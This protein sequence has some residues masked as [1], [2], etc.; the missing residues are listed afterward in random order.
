VGV[1]KT[2]NLQQYLPRLVRYWD[3]DAPGRLHRS[4]EGSMVFVDISGFTKMSERLARHGNVGA[5]EVTEVIDNTFG[6]LLPEAYAFG[7]NLLK[8][9]GDALL[10]LFT[11]EGHQQRAVAGAHAMRIKLREVGTF[12]TT[13]GKVS[14]RMSVGVHS[15]DFDFFLVGD[16]HREFIV[17][18]PAASRTVEMEGAA[19]ANQILISP[20][21]ASHLEPSL[22][23]KPAGPGILLRG[24]P[25]VD[26][27]EF[28]SAT[29]P[30]T[31]LGQFIPTALREV[32]GE[33]RV[34]PEHRATTVAFLHY[35]GFD[36]LLANE[37]GETAGEILQRLIA[38]VQHAADERDVT[39]LATDV[40]PDGGKVILTAGVP[41][42]RGNDEERMLLTLR[43]IAT[44]T[45][46]ELPL[47]IGV[48]RGPVFSGVVGP[49][50]RRTYTV[51]GDVVNLA[52]RLM[53][54]APEGE[55]YSTEEVV[56]AS[57]TIF[58][59]TK[60][61]P[62]FVK[63]KSAAIQAY[64]VAD[65]SGS[66]AAA[67]GHDA[68]LIGRESE[69]KTLLDA[70]G[71]ARE[72][73]GQVVEIAAEVGMGKSRLLQEFFSQA[74]ADRVIT[75]ECRL[76]QA[77]TPYFP[78][79]AM[80]RDVW[81]LNDR[82]EEVNRKRLGELVDAHAPHLRPWMSLLA[83]PLDL[84][85][86]R[87]PEVAQLEDQFRPARTLATV[88]GL[89]ESTVEDPTVFVI[90]DNH[91][92]DDSSGELLEGLIQQAEHD[93][94][95]FVLTRRPGV[96]GFVAAELPGVKRLDLGPL[97]FDDARRFI[98]D[99]TRDAPLL[100]RH[101]DLLAERA[102][103]RP[104]FLLE[105]IEEVRSGGD[106]ETL[107]SSVEGLIGSRIDRLAPPDRNLLRRLAVLGTG[108]RL[109]YTGAVLREGEVETRKQYLKRLG[110]FLV[111]DASGWIQF[112]NALIRDVAYEGLPFKTR[113]ELHARVGDSILRA[114]GDDPESEAALLSI[115][116]FHARHWDDAWHFS[117][118]AG[119]DAKAV[120]ANQTAATFFQRALTA[121]R[122]LDVTVEERAE[123]AEALGDVL[124]QAGRAEE[125]LAVYGRALKIIGDDP[126]RRADILLKRAQV[127]MRT[128]DFAIALRD[129]AVGIAAA[130]PRRQPRR[131]ASNSEVDGAAFDRA[132]GPGTGPRGTEDRP[133]YGGRSTFRGREHR[134]GARPRH[135]G[136]GQLRNG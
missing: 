23:G 57:R 81:G 128:G 71:L 15:G 3:E 97:S 21:T 14:L 125:A 38:N 12:Q 52:A 74:R 120:Y 131:K 82:D 124:E 80:L 53:A 132:D 100:P 43:S 122:Y 104:L 13:A 54:K 102:E 55:I 134:P 19:S 116:Y 31:N 46:E 5:E 22:L 87:S 11:N 85:L 68:P 28:R 75:T 107:P 40:A 136:L 9:G 114:A 25:E 79:R 7:A 133:G 95:M 110:E 90:E 29:S 49:W 67:T 99:A 103:G 16:S 73:E 1:N 24:A 89:L 33:E 92:M 18:G 65:P 101:I 129:S 34:E 115:H 86:E 88:S 70:W 98:I 123:V 50:Y 56:N 4:I 119:N 69:L 63:G 111:M 32:L 84:D 41:H 64:S 60:P 51:M 94:W 83:A 42:T 93:P 37:G 66:R 135:H 130:G 2:P 109:E 76:Y 106:I 20:E 112:R 61:E 127:R 108:F 91:W 44:S 17:A 30:P 121:A 8:F 72:H 118:L 78:F 6:A 105:M 113:L 48:N 58:S 36:E 26:P 47:Q 10:L 59:F 45:P 96:Q 77:A 62:F 27:L 117:R 35:E 126:V 39:F